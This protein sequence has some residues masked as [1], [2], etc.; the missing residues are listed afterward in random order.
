MVKARRIV[1]EEMIASEMQK[2]KYVS[3]HSL[4]MTIPAPIPPTYQG[5]SE[6]EAV[7]AEEDFSYKWRF[8]VFVLTS[9]RTILRLGSLH[10]YQLFG[11]GGYKRGGDGSGGGGRERVKDS[12]SRRWLY[13]NVVR[14]KLDSTADSHLDIEGFRDFPIFV[15]IWIFLFSAVAFSY[16]K[17]LVIFRCKSWDKHVDYRYVN[18][19][20]FK[21][22]QSSVWKHVISHDGNEG[23][24]DDEDESEDRYEEEKVVPAHKVILGAPGSFPISSCNE[25]SIQ[26]L[27]HGLVARAHKLILSLW[28]MPFMKMFTNGMR[29]SGSSEI[30]LSNVSLEAFVAM[31]QFMYHGD[32]DMKN[33]MDMGNFSIQLLLLADQFGITPLH[34]ECY[35]TILEYLSEVNGTTMVHCGFYSEKVLVAQ[36]CYVPFW[37]KIILVTQE[38]D[39]MKIN[40]DSTFITDIPVTVAERPFNMLSIPFELIASLITL[41]LFERS[42]KGYLLLCVDLFSKVY[43]LLC[44]DPFS[45]VYLLSRLRLQEFLEGLDSE[46]R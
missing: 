4:E 45:K 7:E 38:A 23:E 15:S 9:E 6:E 21:Q 29:E 13:N 2:L 28:S 39:G 11:G 44:A 42:V 17:N 30:L 36:A 26:L 32:I 20:S 25:D 8:H 37:D 3:D 33:S 34:Q 1:L 5:L 12:G 41:L 46:L 14:G 40:E 19:M 27:G 24:V 22:N 35:N 43:L 16:Y 10:L 18:V 31:S